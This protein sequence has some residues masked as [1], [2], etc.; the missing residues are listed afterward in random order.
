MTLYTNRNNIKTMFN[1]I[2]GMM[3]LFCLLSAIITR[4]SVSSWQFTSY[5]GIIYSSF[6]KSSF[7]MTNRILFHTNLTLLSLIV[8]FICL[9]HRLS[10]IWRFKVSLHFSSAFFTS[11]ILSLVKSHTVFALIIIT[12]FA[13]FTFAKFRKLLSFFADSAGLCYDWF[14]HGFLLV[15]KSCLESV[16]SHTLAVGLSYYIKV[17]MNV[18]G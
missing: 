16:A 9:S 11:S 4:Q 10:A 17:G 13:Y 7:G 18:N 14:R 3:I 2:I 1:P 15:R 12:I 5:D 6:S 8:A